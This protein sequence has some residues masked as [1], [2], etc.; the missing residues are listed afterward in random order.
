M[1][2]RTTVFANLVIVA[3][4]QSVLA[5]TFEAFF[6]DVKET[7]MKIDQLERGNTYELLV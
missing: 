7:K 5:D 1:A 4:I 2:A 6:Y 3:T